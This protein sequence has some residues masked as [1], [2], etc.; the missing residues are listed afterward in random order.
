MPD[1]FIPR[2]TTAYTTLL[3]EMYNKDVLR[4]FSLKYF[5]ENKKKLELTTLKDFKKTFVVTNTQ[6]KEILELT[7]ASGIKI[8][9][10][11]LKRSERFIKNQIKA[12]IARSMWKNEGFYSVSN[13][14]DDM[15]RN[16]VMLFPKA[17]F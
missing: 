5:L 7:K 3:V 16:A 9:D 4:E 17:N 10:E 15:L 2:D 8:K 14:A 13:E 1:Y 12:L 6:W 11:E